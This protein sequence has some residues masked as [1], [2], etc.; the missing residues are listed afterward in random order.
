MK[1][2]EIFLIF[3][4]ALIAI[5]WFFNPNGNFE[6]VIV[7]LTLSATLGAE[8]YRRKSIKTQIDNP[9][10][11]SR[12]FNFIA[13]ISAQLNKLKQFLKIN[14]KPD[15]NFRYSDSTVFFAERFSQ[16]FP[17]IRS[18]AWFE[19]QEAI[20]RLKVL[21]QEPLSFKEKKFNFN[22]YMVVGRWKSSNY[23]F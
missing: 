22:T 13:F 5:F 18:T 1:I 8:V 15:N 23:K 20:K 17:G 12:Q 19:E 16:A 21:F 14:N 7:F 2:V 10:N 9:D 11:G 4:A 6:P 3:I